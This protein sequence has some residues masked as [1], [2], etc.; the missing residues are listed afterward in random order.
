M[1]AKPLISILTPTFNH[2]NYVGSFIESLLAQNYY[3]W[4]LIIVDD[5]STD[6]N[7]SEIRQ[8]DLKLYEIEGS[9]FDE[10]IYD[11]VMKNKDKFN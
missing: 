7:I 2:E 4:E 5:C 11:Y 10:I 6:N 3:N 1:N 8:C 9:Y